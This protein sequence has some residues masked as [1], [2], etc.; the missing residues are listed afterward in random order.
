MIRPDSPEFAGRVHF[1]GIGGAGMSAVAWLLH[2]RGTE[3]SGSDAAGGPYAEA[4]KAA[5]ISVAV[6]HDPTLVGGAAA[7][8]VSSAVREVNVELSAARAAGIPVWHRSQALAWVV[9]PKR[10]IA[11]AGA[12]GK[13][14]TSAMAVHALRG[15]GIDATFAIG[16]PVLGVDAAVGGGYWGSSDIAVIEADESDGSFLLYEPEV[17]VITNIEPDHLDHYGSEQAVVEA[18]GSFAERAGSLILWHGDP[19]AAAFIAAARLR[20]QTVVTYGESPE[21]AIVVGATG[22]GSPH[23]DFPLTLPVPG[24]HNRLNAAAAWAAATLVG[25]DPGAAAAALSSFA[26]TGR[27][28]EQRGDAAGVTV[29][30]DYAHHPTEIAALLAAAEER[31]VCRL[32]V[33]FQPHLYSRTR[34]LAAEFARALSR[35]GVAVVLTGVYGAREDPEPGVGARTIADLMLPIDGGSVTVVEDLREAAAAAARLA[36]RGDMVLTVGAG[37]VTDAAEWVLDELRSREAQ[38][39]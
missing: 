26:G 14:T 15:A 17:S 18:F 1:I 31:S 7:V 35:P 20:G 38:G 11:I 23:G 22:L 4:L 25:A 3:V 37:S 2:C 28:F 19:H 16:A 27:R 12:H 32:V 34:L 13:T 24:R 9:Y 21:A 36:R 8:V 33:L 6:G 29:V 39:G 10:I 5:G 30:D